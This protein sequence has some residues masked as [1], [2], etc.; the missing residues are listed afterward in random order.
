MYY[1]FL[2]T[3]KYT[4]FLCVCRFGTKNSEARHPLR[5]PGSASQHPECNG[6]APHYHCS[7]YDH[8]EWGFQVRATKA[9]IKGRCKPEDM[10]KL[11]AQNPSWKCL[12]KDNAHNSHAQARTHSHTLIFS[13][14]VLADSSALYMYYFFCMRD[15]R[16]KFKKF[17]SPPPSY[18]SPVALHSTQSAMSL[19]HTITTAYLITACDLPGTWPL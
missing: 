13:T 6:P 9:S 11:R 14:L 8:R 16:T 17:G 18:E 4:F 5:E 15:E 3:G 12:L 1:F 10:G 2:C 7:L 19:L